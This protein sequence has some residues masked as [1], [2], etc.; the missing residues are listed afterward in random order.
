MHGT[1][2]EF[3]GRHRVEQRFQAL[4]GTSMVVAGSCRGIYKALEEFERSFLCLRGS[5]VREVSMRFKAFQ[6][7]HGMG[8]CWGLSR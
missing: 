6:L 1:L 8:I 4:Q 2:E 3:T 7:A 5:G